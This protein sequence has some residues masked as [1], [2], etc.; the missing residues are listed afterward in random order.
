K[1]GGS[2]KSSK[3]QAQTRLQPSNAQSGNRKPAFATERSS[4]AII[5]RTLGSH[6]K[7]RIANTLLNRAKFKSGNRKHASQPREVKAAIANTP[8]TRS[9]KRQTQ[10]G[11]AAP[12]VRT[13]LK[14]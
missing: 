10:A 4:K 5:A 14:R 11:F 13:I 9:S 8:R 7:L 3:R 1:N 6:A 2:A 12:S